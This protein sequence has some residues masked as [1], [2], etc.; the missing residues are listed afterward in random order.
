MTEA[1]GVSGDRGRGT[2]PSDMPSRPSERASEDTGQ[3]TGKRPSEV[4]DRSEQTL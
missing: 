3:S 4:E 1:A 2:G